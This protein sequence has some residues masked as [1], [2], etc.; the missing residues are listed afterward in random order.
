M[1]THTHTHNSHKLGDAQKRCRPSALFPGKGQPLDKEVKEEC[2]SRRK[3]QCDKL[4]LHF[5]LLGVLGKVLEGSGN[6]S[7]PTQ[8]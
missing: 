2:C 5:H 6:L 7:F 8:R 4:C 1:H 3:M